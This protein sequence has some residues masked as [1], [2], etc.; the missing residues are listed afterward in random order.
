MVIARGKRGPSPEKGHGKTGRG[1]QAQSAQ[2]EMPLLVWVAEWCSRRIGNV[3]F[4]ATL[5]MASHRLPLK[6]PASRVTP[7]CAYTPGFMPAAIK[8]QFGPVHNR[9][10]LFWPYHNV[11]GPE[12]LR[13]AKKF[14]CSRF[15][16][17][18]FLL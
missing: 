6:F 2:L 15:S 17:A 9:K 14:F 8:P 10:L 7:L 3:A 1:E 18:V 12:F 4:D 13:A 16:V 5:G 11:V